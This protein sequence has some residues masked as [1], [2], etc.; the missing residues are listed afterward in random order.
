[1]RTKQSTNVTSYA[2]KTAIFRCWGERK[3]KKRKK[4]KK[5]KKKEK[6]KKKRGKGEREAE[7]SLV[8]TY[9]LSVVGRRAV[10]TIITR[11]LLT[12]LRLLLTRRLK[13]QGIIFL[14]GRCAPYLKKITRRRS[15]AI[16]ICTVYH[17]ESKTVP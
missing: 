8:D 2:Q 1:M 13:K 7:K 15:A 6:K 5:E 10:G 17:D 14:K 12:R 4:R 11:R 16:R 9:E 3:K